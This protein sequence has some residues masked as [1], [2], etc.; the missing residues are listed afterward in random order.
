MPNIFEILKN[1]KINLCNLLILFVILG[2]VAVFILF[3]FLLSQDY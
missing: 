1:I 3:S 2:I